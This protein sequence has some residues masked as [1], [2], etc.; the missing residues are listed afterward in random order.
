MTASSVETILILDTNAVQHIYEALG[1]Q[2]LDEISNIYDKIVINKNV[3]AEIQ[4]FGNLISKRN[5]VQEFDD[6]Y[7]SNFNESSKLESKI[8][9][10]EKL[11]SVNENI[12][13]PRY[14][15]LTTGVL[16]TAKTDIGDAY[17]RLIAAD[18]QGHA[19]EFL[20]EY[21]GENFDS[22]FQLLTNDIKDIERYK[23]IPG[24]YSGSNNDWNL[25]TLSSQYNMEK[26]VHVADFYKHL[27]ERGLISH[28]RYNF[29]TEKFTNLLH[30]HAEKYPGGSYDKIIQSF[31][32]SYTATKISEF[33]GP[34]KDYLVSK[35]G[36]DWPSKVGSITFGAGFEILRKLGPAFDAADLYFTS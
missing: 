17:N 15:D 6:W 7:Y 5:Y 9:T 32:D 26:P 11:Y 3:L 35:F 2:G 14:P 19:K 20:Q 24:S 12:Y 10:P 23:S 25:E 4:D 1:R 30:T 34:A 16:I 33:T 8:I 31:M 18:S 28:D 36:E 22:K 27:L 29:I 13:D 21:L